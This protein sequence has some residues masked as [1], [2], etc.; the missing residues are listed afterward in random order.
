[1]NTNPESKRFHRRSMLCA[2]GVLFIFIVLFIRLLYLQL[3]EHHFYETL[4][5]RNVISIVPVKPDRG[6]IYDRNG[7]LLAK[8]IPVYSLMLIPGRIENLK[9]TVTNLSKIIQLTPEEI[10][11]FYHTVK[12]YYPYQAVPLKQQLTENEVDS[13]YINQY[14]FPGVAIQTNM[15]RNYPAAN[16]MSNVIGYVGRIN[17]NELAQLNPTDYTASDEIGKAG[18]EAEDETLLHGT[19]GSEEAEIDANG[20]VVRI[21]KKTPPI[22]GD[23]IYLTIDSKLQAYAEQ[24]LGSNTGAIVAIQPS[25]G[26]VL[27]LATNP[28]YDPNMFV[29][30]MT[31]AQYHA[32][33]TA[34]DHPLFNRAT[35]ATY[36]PGSTVKP[37]ISFSALNDGVI[38][39]QDYIFDPGWFRLPNTQ[40]IFHNWLK[41]GFGWVNV[42]K[43]IMVSCDTFFYQLATVLGIDRL[44]QALTQFGF[45]QLTG[46]DLPGERAG[47]VPSP[48][49]KQKHIGQAWYAGDT[50]VAGIGQGYVTAT[51]LQLAAAVSIMAERGLKFQPSVLLKLVQ[52]NG[53]VTMM[54]PISGTPIVAKDPKTW[55]VVIQAMQ[56]VTSNSQGGTAYSTF[57]GAA[58]TSAGKTGTA[59]VYASNPDDQNNANQKIEPER[60]QNNHLFIVFAPVDNPQIAVAV[61][62]EHIHGMSQRAV[63]IARQLMDFYFKALKA[64]EALNAKT[65]PP[66]PAGALPVPQENTE[67]PVITDT[68]ANA[69]ENLPPPAGPSLLP[70]ATMKSILN[71]DPASD[72]KN[73][74]PATSQKPLDAKELEQDTQQEIQQDTQK[75]NDI[76]KTN[77]TPSVDPTTLQQQM[78]TKVDTRME[79][80]NSLQ[81]PDA[82]N[83]ASKE[84]IQSNATTNAQQ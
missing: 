34:P 44:D 55:D 76:K 78:E 48:A 20:K 15:I 19:M 84:Q 27:A 70:N 31:N 42:T 5:K 38:T 39:T 2:A 57:A 60:L 49:W 30:G 66:L 51:P 40:H 46:I 36:A 24:L 25:T 18:V 23:N 35:R 69:K 14:R 59:Q 6:L 65:N 80:E 71:K 13:F 61:V 67:K 81:K 10:E 53:I 62:V 72:P 64:Q 63:Q 17:A 22:A 28:N 68:K 58:Y 21:L 74:T 77:P 4:S 9:D 83:S 29:Q 45:G 33:T 50:V 12:Q 43:A 79:L 7:V 11:G 56:D 54:Q 8:N 1:M 26:Q 75:T 16:A 3:F 41:K 82:N 52:P 73:T 37:F 32:I 47:I